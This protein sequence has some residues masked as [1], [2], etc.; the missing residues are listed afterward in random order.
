MAVAS[1]SASQN[2]VSSQETKRTKCPG[3]RL[4][5]GRIYDSENG[6]TCHQCRQKTRDFSASCK[7]LKRDKQCTIKY[8]HKCLLNRYGEKAEEV[9]L[10]DDW[11]CPKCR[12]N[13][14]CSFCMKKRG[15]K[16]TGMLV[17]KAKATGFSSVSEMLQ[18]KG[19]ENLHGT[20]IKDTIS[21]K[22]QSPLTK[23]YVVSSPVKPGKENSLNVDCD[24]EFNSQN[25]TPNSNEKKS[26]KVKRE[27]LKE[28]SNRKKDYG[29]SLR[30]S[31]P[32]RAK[33]SVETSK[34]EV[35]G[36]SKALVRNSDTMRYSST[37]ESKGEKGKKAGVSN[38]TK[39]S[40]GISTKGQ[41]AIC[42]AHLENTNLNPGVSNGVENDNAGAKVK[43]AVEFSKVKKCD[44]DLEE[45]YLVDIQLPQGT[46][47]VTVA[48]IDLLPKDVGHV[49]QFLEFCAAFGE[50]LDIRKGQAESVIREIIRGRSR[51]Q[52]PYSIGQIHIQ[53]L[54]LMQKDMGTKFPSLSTGGKDSWFQALGQC[55]S[56]SQ[57]ALEEFPSNIFDKGVDAYNLLDSSKKLKLLNFLCD[58]VLSTRTLRSWMEDQ[59][60]K[61]GDQKKEAKEKVLLAKDKE[62]QL[63]KKM[64]DKLAEAIIAKNGAP[65]SISEHDAIVAKIKREVAQA[66]RE[67]LEAEGMLPKKRERA[68]AVRTEPILSGVNGHAFWKL[69]GYTGELDILL[70]DLGTWDAVVTDDKWFGYGVVQKQEVEK[71]IS[72]LRT[73]RLRIQKV[74]DKLPF[75]SR[76]T[77]S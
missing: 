28:L 63:K 36:N 69:R 66:H 68:D 58:E 29:T 34:N 25:L 71:Y 33:T 35:K 1:N 52:L 13:C 42:D 57:C 27:G 9:E 44:M 17:Q 26:K 30:E 38:V 19:P 67:M 8:C 54:S 39:N 24:S 32:K 70:Q 37:E 46:S 20:T 11:K 31:S 4:V 56:E 3:V 10:L 75:A 73:K 61:F 7:N 55:V 12:G 59:N 5:G 41:P 40:E 23:E 48:G 2:V 43:A 51:R 50:V 15:H 65:L 74:L 21:R 77:S 18:V 6:K 16:P 62:K 14:N 76:E 53:L 60:S 72:T 47:L 45:K 64:Q 22:K 49:L